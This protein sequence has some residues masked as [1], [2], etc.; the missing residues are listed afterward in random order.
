ML[1]YT[2]MLLFI[3]NNCFDYEL[4]WNLTSNGLFIITD[5][6]TVEPQLSDHLCATSTLK[7]FR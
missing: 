3:Q 4:C 1:M 7:M 2:M 6:Y 5:A